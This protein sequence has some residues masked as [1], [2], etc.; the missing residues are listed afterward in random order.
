MSKA[1]QE[2]TAKNH[3]LSILTVLIGTIAL[4]AAISA[5]GEPVL[6]EANLNQ[7]PMQIGEY[8]AIPG[9]LPPSIVKEL[10]T[11]AYLAR[12]YF[13]PE[14]REI[15]LYIGYYGTAK[16]GRTGHNPY[17]CLPG[18][19]WGI[20]KKDILKLHR[21]DKNIS[22]NV[23]YLLARKGQTCEAILHWYQSSN[24]KVFKSGFQ[25]NIARFLNG[26][27]RNKNDG[28]F[29]QVTMHLKDTSIDSDLTD[30]NSF[31]AK[32]VTYLEQYWP[33]EK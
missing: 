5:R 15:S 4:T 30:F 12:T 9:E 19:G 7:I 33:T 13:T 1:H 28:A 31:S 8:K 18:A 21:T 17:A 2:K 22:L 11:D 10:N 3:F 14:G 16:G 29:V 23:N 27:F 20:L 26:I 32:I 25:H 24:G 6:V